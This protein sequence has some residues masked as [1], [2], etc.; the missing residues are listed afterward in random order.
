MNKIIA[1]INLLL[2]TRFW[3]SVKI[4]YWIDG[5]MIFHTVQRIG[6]PDKALILNHRNI[7]K[8][9]HGSIYNKHTK[10]LL[11]NGYVSYEVYGY[12]GWFKR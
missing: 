12:L 7:T 9:F 6:I 11:K 3:Y 4:V 5:V 1:K 8:T 2:G 10:N